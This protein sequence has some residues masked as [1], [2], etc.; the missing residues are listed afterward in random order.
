MFAIAFVVVV[1]YAAFDYMQN[2]RGFEMVHN[3]SSSG[4][5]GSFGSTHS[6]IQSK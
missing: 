6:W 4:A 5:K 2:D 3:K 1:A